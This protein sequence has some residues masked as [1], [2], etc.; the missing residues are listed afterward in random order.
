MDLPD[1]SLYDVYETSQDQTLKDSCPIFLKLYKIC[2]LH[3]GD[4]MVGDIK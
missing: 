2:S 4:A 1:E 3:A